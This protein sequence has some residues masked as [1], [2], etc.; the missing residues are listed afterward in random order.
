MRERIWHEMVDAKLKGIYTKIYLAEQR[1]INKWF[2]AFILIFSASG[3]LG[4]S[5]WKDF[6]LATS[7]L[8]SG[9]ALF[10]IIGTEFLPNEKVFTKSEKIIDFYFNHFNQI[11]N[12]WYDHYNYIVSDSEAQEKFYSIIKSESEINKIVNDVIRNQN[13]KMLSTAE[14]ECDNYFKKIFNL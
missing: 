8:V 14:I 4:W 1:K 13:S 11:E 2:N 12:L 6:P 3:V 9:M 5:F 7:I 10:K